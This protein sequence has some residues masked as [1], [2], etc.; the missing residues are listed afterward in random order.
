MSI[1]DELKQYAYGYET[2]VNHRLLG[3]ADR[4]DEAHEREIADAELWAA[5][6]EGQIEEMG[7]IALPK[8]ADGVPIHLGDVMEWCDYDG[9]VEVT[10]TVDAVGAGCFFAWD[11]RNCRYAQKCANAYRHHHKLTVEDVL[12]EFTDR[13]LEWVGKSGSVA[14]VGTWSDVAAEYAAKLQLREGA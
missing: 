6:T 9:E 11:A 1:T 14:E 3:I 5:P 8:D 2:M 7:Y 12:R 13:V 4:I 10:C